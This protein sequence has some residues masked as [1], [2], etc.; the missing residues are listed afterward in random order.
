MKF[1]RISRSNRLWLVIGLTVLPLFLLTFNDFSKQHRAALAEIEFEA[2]LILKGVDYA[3]DAS[4]REIEMIFKAMAGADNM[5]RLDPEDCDGLARRLRSVHGGLTNLGAADLDGNVFCSATPMTQA[6]SVKDRP[7]FAEARLNPGITEGH[8]LIGRISGKPGITFGYAVPDV[9]NLPRAFLF[10]STRAEWFDRFTTIATLP[11]GWTSQIRTRDGQTISRYPN[12][13]GENGKELSP[14]SRQRFAQALADN[15][16]TVII[17]GIDDVERLYVMAPLRVAGD[18]LI[19]SVGVPT[20]QSL[21]A[22]E[23][24]FRQRL[25]LL[26]LVTLASIIFA[27]LFLHEMVDRKF[28]EALG[29]MTRL[30]KAL[31]NVPAYI[32]LK[33]ASGRY[34]YANRKTLALF[35]VDAEGLKGKGDDA[36]FPPE[37]V[38]RLRQVDA[39]VLAGQ[40]TDEIITVD[41]EQGQRS[42][43]HEIKSPILEDGDTAPWG[44][45]GIS[46]DITQTRLAEEALTKF[47]RAVEQSPESIFFTDQKGNIEYVNA[48]FMAATGY[49]REEVIGQNPRT[50]QSG[51]TPRERYDE[52]WAALLAG[53]VWRGELINKRKDG[54][55]YLEM[56]TISPVRQAD[57]KITHYVAVKSDITAQRKDQEELEEYRIGL[58]WLVEQ[59]TRELAQA[60]EAAEV[61]SRAKSTFLANMSHEIRTPMN[62]IMGLGFLLGQSELNDD[63]QE[64]VRKIHVAAKHLLGI[65]N[66]VLD[67]S[68]IE[69][70]KMTLDDSV[71]SPAEELQAVA[72]VI[73]EEARRKGL[74]IIVEADNLPP[75]VSGDPTRLRQAILNFAG[76]AI[77]FTE[78]GRVRLYGEVLENR[79]NDYLLRLSVSDTGPGI[80]PEVQARL[81]TAFEQADGSSTRRMGGTGLGLAISRHLARLMGGDAGVD[82]VPGQGSTFWLTVRVAR[83]NARR[84]VVDMAELNGASLRHDPPWH[85]LIVEDSEINR[86]IMGEILGDV[87]IT[88]EMAEDG[89]K[90]VDMAARNRYNLILMDLQMPEM[91]GLEACRRIRQ[92][93]LNQDVPVIALTA[94]AFDQVRHETR[95]AGMN[96][97]VAKPV[98]PAM[99]FAALLRWLPARQE[100]TEQARA[101]EAI[102]DEAEQAKLLHTLRQALATG[103]I[104]ASHI[105]QALHPA[106]RHKMMGSELHGLDKAMAHYAYDDALAILAQWQ[107]PAAMSEGLG[108]AGQ[109][110]QEER[111][112]T[113]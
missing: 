53:R 58:E 12:I 46:V 33:D 54:S 41:G 97:F 43:Y 52:L 39:Q 65:L 78:Q 96:D 31:D 98:E 75:L 55:E 47:S 101:H 69:A 36:F 84:N 61:A 91:D 26:T 62:A 83:T 60:K 4:V 77:K 113:A 14:E 30:K 93:G 10:A 99:L 45:C 71:F 90:A 29:E 27:R 2:R 1:D 86:D 95:Q 80:A 59:R 63:Q 89:V 38:E 20:E 104:A 22:V 82:S 81:F 42:F 23:K 3:E 6:V 13:E 18:A 16:S 110:G 28:G 44:L 51:K 107:Q 106:L 56:A 74:A 70:G 24:Q 9:E 64:K 73:G 7:W 25:I 76:N 5:A 50:L 35:G 8:F 40:N 87:G 108:N 79:P 37:T 15:R 103:D 32:Y 68:K 102:P 111:G 112:E 88:I 109:A 57:G 34:R 92:A 94:N 72:S 48:A 17:Q 19:L 11:E 67:L 100:S 49:A 85:V 105:Y 66:D 21:N